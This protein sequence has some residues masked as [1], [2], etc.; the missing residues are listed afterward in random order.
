M[1][2]VRLIL[3]ISTHFSWDVHQMDVKSAFLHGDLSAEIFCH[4][5]KS[6]IRNTNFD[7]GGGIGDRKYTSIYLVCLCCRPLVY[8]CKKHKLVSL[9]TTE[10]EY[11]GIVN[12]GR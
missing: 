3:Y 6:L 8:S 11:H 12:I 1:N 4:S 5:T 2:Y 10:T 7:Y 9:S